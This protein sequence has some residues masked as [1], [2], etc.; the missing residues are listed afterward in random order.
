M[1]FGNL[2]V[3]HSALGSVPAFS[4]WSPLH[5]QPGFPFFVSIS[6]REEA[7]NEW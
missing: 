3:R 2:R 5:R 6:L 1:G 4:S 7:T